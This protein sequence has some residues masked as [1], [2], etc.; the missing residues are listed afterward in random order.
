MKHIALITFALVLFSCKKEGNKNV[1][2]S[3]QT[4]A[5]DERGK[6]ILKEGKY[7]YSANNGALAAV[8]I[9]DNEKV[10]E[11]SIK[12]DNI[13]YVLDQ[14]RSTPTETFYE[15]NGINARLTSD[16]LIIIQGDIT[17]DLVK[18]K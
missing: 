9:T 10:K 17:I 7:T 16:S 14:K 11:L 3:N 12:T 6:S 2:S 1:I 13:K 8:V 15:R 4:T 18:V 5:S